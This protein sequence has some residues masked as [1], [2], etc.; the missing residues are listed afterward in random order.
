MSGER[1]GW[2]TWDKYL[3]A[4]IVGQDVMYTDCPIE[5]AHAIG[6]TRETIGKCWPMD[7]AVAY[8]LASAGPDAQLKTKD[9]VNQHTKMAAAMMT[10]FV[11]YG[12][13]P[14]PR[15]D[16]CG[17]DEIEGYE[18]TWRNPVLVDGLISWRTSPMTSTPKFRISNDTF[19]EQFFGTTSTSAH[20]KL[21]LGLL[22][23]PKYTPLR[24]EIEKTLGTT[25][26]ALSS[27]NTPFIIKRTLGVCKWNGEKYPEGHEK[28]GK[29]MLCGH[30]DRPKIST[31]AL[32]KTTKDGKIQD[33][34][35]SQIWSREVGDAAVHDGWNHD[36][37]ASNFGHKWSSEVATERVVLWSKVSRSLAN[38]IWAS[39]PKFVLKQINASL[40][41][42]QG[43]NLNCI[44]RE[45]E[46]S[47]ATGRILPSTVTYTWKNW[48]WLT[49]L[50]A[51][52]AQTSKKN[53]KEHDLVNGWK[54]T[55]YDSR[56]SYGYEIAKFRWVPGK[57]NDKFDKDTHT[58][59]VD[60][61]V[62]YTIAP[63]IEDEINSYYVNIGGRSY[64]SKDLPYRFKEKKDAYNFKNFL[65]MMAMKC[66]AVNKE[67]R[68]W[69]GDKG[70]ENVGD[71]DAFRVM[72]ASHTLWMGMDVDPETT[73][74]PTEIMEA[75]LFGS[76]QDY[77]EKIVY[78]T[79][80]TKKHYP[81][82][83]IV[84]AEK[85]EETV[86]Q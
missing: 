33:N 43:R 78:L 20:V 57:V 32:V 14:D 53:R 23:S 6:K 25:K 75:L 40:R 49:Q 64:R 60:G 3:K 9:L 70:N 72:K 69:D 76:P 44:K 30:H 27:G 34:R 19:R 50:R 59:L 21:A 22:Y 17:H 8:S 4:G 67:G 58:S 31:W 81:R 11:G 18:V 46:Y 2:S 24:K 5:T 47:E 86:I 61:V 10:Q 54:W 48:G 37:F 62:S 83:I 79:E 29:A 26:W 13:V 15:V 39:D 85:K 84:K 38:T 71:G 82:P 52:I 74:T 73:P 1:Q 45:G 7:A 80:D 28:A 77:D 36:M 42:M 16:R 41:R 68:K 65:S 12:S 56:T 63:A 66:G 55:K 35:F 51:W